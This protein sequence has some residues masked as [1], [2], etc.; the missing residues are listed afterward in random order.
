[1]IALTNYFTNHHHRLPSMDRLKGAL[2]P[3]QKRVASLVKGNHSDVLIRTPSCA[4]RTLSYIRPLIESYPPT[5]TGNPRVLVMVPTKESADQVGSL[6][7]QHRDKAAMVVSAVGGS[8]KQVNIDQLRRGCDY[9][10]G[11]PGRLNWLLGQNKLPSSSLG[12]IV[13]DHADLLLT[14]EMALNVLKSA[15]PANAQRIICV[16]D[17]DDWL[18]DTLKGVTR[19]GHSLEIVEDSQPRLWTTKQQSFT[20]VQHSF[21]KVSSTDESRQL[22][23]LIDAWIRETKGKTIVFARS[24]GDLSVMADDPLF[25]DWI[26][27]SADMSPSVQAQQVEK[28]VKTKQAVLLCTSHALEGVDSGHVGLVVS[29]GCPV[30]VDEYVGRVER[31]KPVRDSSKVI[32]LLRKGEFDLFNKWRGSSGFSFKPNPVMSSDDL[33]V[34]FAD[35]LVGH[36]RNGTGVDLPPGELVQSASVLAK[37]HGD[38]MV[39]GLLSMVEARKSVLTKTSP[40]SGQVGYSPVLL[41]DPFMK[42]VRNYD[43]AAKLVMGCI[44]TVESKSAK[45]GRIALSSKGFIVD[46]PKDVVQ[47]VVGSRKLKQ[48]NVK[49]IYLSVLPPLVQN[50]RLFALKQSVKDR[51]SVVRMTKPKR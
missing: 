3:L 32:T 30:G 23:F 25:A 51:K 44:G 41:F 49:A 34:S 42:K 2:S 15:V 45:L 5:K 26:P 21:A 1:M 37:M 13:L 9:L 33:S 11:T 12:A 19:H 40:L 4:E 38:T 46:V 36:L 28:F 7:H 47:A 8:D 29:L 6:F 20:S 14:S 17:L 22:R 10:I 48:R 39:A 24:K 35:T 16:E 50:D 31:I 27:L 43:A 18:Q